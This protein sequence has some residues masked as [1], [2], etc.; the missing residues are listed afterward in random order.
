[1]ALVVHGSACAGLTMARELASLA[2][3]QACAGL[4][5]GGHGLCFPWIRV[6]MVRAWTC[7]AVG[8]AWARLA[9]GTPCAG[10][11]MIRP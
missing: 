1:M 4:A 10:L 3:G 6:A 11:A 2:V 7:L 5:K 8:R 9:M